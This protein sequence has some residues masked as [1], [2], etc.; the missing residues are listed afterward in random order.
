MSQYLS[1]KIEVS[2]STLQ[3]ICNKLNKKLRI[4]GT[5]AIAK[6]INMIY[7]IESRFLRKKQS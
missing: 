5:K 7:F 3:K 2:L 1:G 4:A 6:K